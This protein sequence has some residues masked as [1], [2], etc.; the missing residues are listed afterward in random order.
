M[1]LAIKHIDKTLKDLPNKMKALIKEVTSKQ[2]RFYS[3]TS[4]NFLSILSLVYHS[5]SE[6]SNIL[7]KTFKWLC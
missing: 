6:K 2:K 3:F 4:Y 7:H 5:D 1:Y